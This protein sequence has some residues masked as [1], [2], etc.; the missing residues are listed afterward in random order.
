VTLFSLD[1]AMTK[2]L[3]DFLIGRPQSVR[4][5]NVL[6]QKKMIS[7]G[8]PQGCVLSPL[9]FILYTNDCRSHHT[10]RHFMKFADDTVLVSLL[11]DEEV[12]HGPVTTDF[13]EWCGSHFLKLNVQKTKDMV[14]DFRK[15][16][17]TA[18]PT[19]IKGT[20]VE[21]VDS[22]KYL[23]TIIDKNLT[24]DLNTSTICKKGLQ[25]LYFLRRLKSFNVD[26][27]LMVL[28]YRSFIESVLTFCLISFYGNLSIK[29]KNHLH[30]IVRDANKINGMQQLAL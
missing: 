8:S 19:I 12:D 15:T 16:P 18:Y 5:N 30:K 6:S 1:P 3:T 29:N 24:H 11:Q 22:Y 21:M 27:T 9:L 20:A 7:T 28:F 17:H 10:D 23:G 2:W 4:I 13:V 26:K 14:I 25:R